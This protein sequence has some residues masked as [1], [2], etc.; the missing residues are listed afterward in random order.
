MTTPA[1]RPQGR[2]RFERSLFLGIVALALLLGAVS[3]ISLIVTSQNLRSLFERLSRQTGAEAVPRD[4]AFFARQHLD[5]LAQATSV[6]LE[7]A[8]AGCSPDLAPAAVECVFA[9][10]AA[11]RA[12]PAAL[13]VRCV[14]IYLK[15]EGAWILAAERCA[16]RPST[17]GTTEQRAGK[18][19]M[20]G[21]AAGD[22]SAESVFDEPRVS[23]EALDRFLASAE[24]PE[25]RWIGR[26]ESLAAWSVGTTNPAEPRV[27]VASASTDSAIAARWRRSVANV[28]R[29]SFAPFI[30]QLVWRQSVWLLVGIAL[31][32][33]L[34]VF[35]SRILS[36]RVSRPLSEL[37]SAM[38]EV[39]RGNLAYRTPIGTQE[40]FGFLA[41]S[42][43]SMTENIERLNREARETARMRREI[44]MAREIQLKLFPHEL[45]SLEGFDLDASNVPSLEVSGDY[46]D[47][48]PWGNV[49]ATALA[50]ADVSGKGIPA[51][52]LMSNVQACL[53]SQAVRPPE[54]PGTWMASMNRQLCE[55]IES[56][57]FVTMFLAV[58]EPSTSRLTY[59]NG[60]H[61]PPLLLRADGTLEELSEGGPLLGAFPDVG[62]SSADTT[63]YEGDVLLIYT[64]GVSEAATPSGEQF[65]ERRLVEL[66]RETR[67]APAVAIVRRVLEEVRRH[68]GLENQADDMT[69]IVLKR[70]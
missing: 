60:G 18:T 67:D 58:H 49:G 34:G 46:Y 28:E 41:A 32:T 31:V 14:R 54:V 44:E 20:P 22:R 64:D 6:A 70:V 21:A 10:L 26:I 12:V 56:G 4:L 48:L 40:E 53:R 15:R 65:E 39:S 43:N 45:P 59:V 11:E 5:H 16:G 62:Y 55:S 1:T 33:V 2:T 19:P 25:Q 38:G 35:V 17:Q 47:V 37:V 13:T 61:N 68:S 63:L 30:A 36:A 7:R 52:L 8:S 3:M 29:P 51:A 23:G 57:R 69:L 24:Q 27:L 42:F 50:I 66:L 9:R